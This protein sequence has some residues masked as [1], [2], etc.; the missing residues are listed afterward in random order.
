VKPLELDQEF[1]LS[2]SDLVTTLNQESDEGA[3]VVVEGKKDVHALS[4]LGFRGESL[5]LCNNHSILDLPET[6]V[7]YTKV[8]LLFDFDRTGRYLTC[9]AASLLERRVKIDLNFRRRL[10]TASR[11]RIHYIE[12]LGRFHEYLSSFYR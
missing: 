9:K 3:L 2:L 4:M 5:M 7:N 6:A 12:E 1:L 8:I 10:R 11:G